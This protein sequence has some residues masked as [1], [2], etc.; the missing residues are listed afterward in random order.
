[1]RQRE[2]ENPEEREP[3]F[4]PHQTDRR[5]GSHPR[6]PARA[7]RAARS[8]STGERPAQGSADTGESKIDKSPVPGERR[9]LDQRDLAPFET[10]D[11][12]IHPGH[13]I[14][15]ASCRERV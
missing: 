1:M 6:G 9:G 13:Q 12:A 5:I 3:L 14:G 2:I 4:G 10:E 11:A 15:R 8:V 7:R